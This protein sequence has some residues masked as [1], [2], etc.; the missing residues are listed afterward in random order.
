MVRIVVITGFSGS[1][2]STAIK[3]LEDEGFYCVDN[4]PMALLPKFVELCEDSG[5]I[6]R[7]AIG[8]DVRG[9]DFLKS[10]P[11]VLG[12]LNSEG[13]DVEI[14]FL[15]SSDEVLLSRFSETRRIHPLAPSGQLTEGILK[16]KIVLSPLRKEANKIIDSS[17]FNVHQLKRVISDY[18]REDAFS[19]K[20]VLSIVSFGFKYGPLY[21]ADIIMDVRFL[22]N[23]NF[24]N[25]LKALTGENERVADFVMKSDKAEGFMERFSGMINYL[26][27][28]YIVEGKSYLT[29]GLGC[30]GGRHRSVAIAEGLA[31]RLV[32]G[33][34]KLR[35]LHRDKER[36]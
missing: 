15:E 7:I 19:K 9:G 4:L 3:A 33:E 29:I 24:V 11:E 22:P 1:G 18:V 20:V 13:N 31:S 16:E 26:L 36:V 25:E 34:Y 30:T 32:D 6:S 23:P 17:T 12:R 21:E 35:V 10:F 27:P 14:I 5:E 28:E 2:K 8:V